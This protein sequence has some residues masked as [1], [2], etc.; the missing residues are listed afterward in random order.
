MPLKAK[1]KDIEEV[2]ED[3]RG[4]YKH[5]EASGMHVL[6]VEAV[7]GLG[8]EDVKGLKDA[9]SSERGLTAK[10]EKALAAFK[11][12]DPNKARDALEK[13][14]KFSQLDPE[15][16]A[17]K[18]AEVKLK[19]LEG[20]LVEKHQG[21]VTG[22]KKEISKLTRLVDKFGVEAKLDKAMDT[23]GVLPEGKPVL[24][25][26]LRNFIKTEITD[27]DLTIKVVGADGNP[28]IKDGSAAHM[29]MADLV[30]KMKA[31]LPHVFKG[32][33]KGGSG[34]GGSDVPGLT[35]YDDNPYAKE[36]HN[37]TQQMVLEKSNPELA[38]KMKAAAQ[39]A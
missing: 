12:I 24:K 28:I 4:H 13:V 10:H 22:L 20:Q 23:S 39:N 26:H 7:D 2:S 18:L 8:L 14:E 38:K 6:D 11:D 32:S 3:L 19:S 25:S 15:K 17:D 21:E 37:F 31:D 34:A 27:S 16:E 1:I 29:D 9:L 35:K 33:G 5:D 36:T 30:E